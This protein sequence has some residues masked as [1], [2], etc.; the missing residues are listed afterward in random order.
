VLPLEEE[1]CEGGRLR[2]KAIAMK[3]LIRR[4][5]AMIYCIFARLKRRAAL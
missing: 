3:D 1:K 2:E 5:I 4:E